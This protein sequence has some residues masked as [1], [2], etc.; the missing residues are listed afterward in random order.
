MADDIATVERIYAVADQPFT[1]D[2]R[3]AMDTFM[4]AH[5]RGRHGT[6]VYDLTD[7]GLDATERRTALQ[8]YVDRFEVREE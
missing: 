8:P 3:A 6:I 2:A 4:A 7:F 5:P 1:D